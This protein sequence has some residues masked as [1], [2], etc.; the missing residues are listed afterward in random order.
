MKEKAG[1]KMKK[2]HTIF[3]LKITITLLAFVAAIGC[4]FVEIEDSELENAISD[5]GLAS[6]ASTQSGILDSEVEYNKSQLSK[7]E[8]ASDLEPIVSQDTLESVSKP[9]TEQKILDSEAPYLPIDTPQVVSIQRYF[10]YTVY[11]HDDGSVL[12]STESDENAQQ[13]ASQ[14]I[15]SVYV[16]SSNSSYPQTASGHTVIPVDLNIGAGGK[17]IWLGYS[18]STSFGNPIRSFEVHSGGRRHQSHSNFYHVKNNRGYPPVGNRGA[19][20]N[21]GAGGDYIYLLDNTWNGSRIKEIA[22]YVRPGSGPPFWACPSSW[23]W[24]SSDLNKGAGG[25]YVHLLAK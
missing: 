3:V 21:E 23:D 4:E 15:H 16:H 25:E 24:C 10:D 19:D 7:I 1:C 5:E 17:Y 12:Y 8:N 20:L 18:R 11:E 2:I 9:Y 14:Y 13:R 6:K 22:I